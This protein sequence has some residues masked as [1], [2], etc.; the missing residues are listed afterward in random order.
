MTAWGRGVVKGTGNAVMHTRKINEKCFGL[1]MSVF[2][3]IT[4]KNIR[5]KYG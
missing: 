3:P 4:E 2:H 5:S 1:N